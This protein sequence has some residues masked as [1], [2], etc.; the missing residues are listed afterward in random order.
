MRGV[1]G[2]R[3]GR[4][5]STILSP[6]CLKKKTAYLR[7]RQRLPCAAASAVCGRRESTILSPTCLSTYYTFLCF[8]FFLY[9]SSRL[10][11]YDTFNLV[12][13]VLAAHFR[14]VILII[15]LNFLFGGASAGLSRLTGIVGSMRLV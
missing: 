14:L 8:F 1:Q 7:I 4:R 9:I 5:E 12:Q 10:Y 6:T 3:S 13:F 2:G 15:F 11:T